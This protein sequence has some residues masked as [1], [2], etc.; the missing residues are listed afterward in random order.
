MVFVLSLNESKF[1]NN[2]KYCTYAVEQEGSL[3]GMELNVPSL[4]LL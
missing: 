1:Y 3:P 4:Q 2:S